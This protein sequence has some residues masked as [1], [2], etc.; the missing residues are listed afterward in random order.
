MS[1]ARA[2]IEANT[3]PSPVPSVPEIRL[4]QASAV[5][6]IW[7]MTES[8]LDRAQLPPPFW[9]FPWAGGQALA[10]YLLDHPDTVRGKTVVD[11]ASGSGLVAIA[12]AM[13]G[14]ASV[15]ANDI[16]SYS[17]A[18]IALNADLN[19]VAIAVETGDLL[20][21][22]PRAVDVYLA[23]DI[24]YEKSM[25]SA[26]LSFFSRAAAQGSSVLIGDPHRSYFPEGLKRM[27]DYDIVTVA[28][29]EDSGIKAA[30]VWA[31]GKAYE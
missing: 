25:S 6:P 30:T 26:M 23:G 20:A 24:A 31:I 14:A 15:I 29:I 3:A 28:D 22:A 2:F 1:D 19:G 12:A 21:G 16:D 27:A 8:E 10:R 9:A 5:T 18:A 13:A 17:A 7:E 11:I 4:W